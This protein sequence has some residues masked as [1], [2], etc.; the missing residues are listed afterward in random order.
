MADDEATP[1]APK[2]A[3]AGPTQSRSRAARKTTARKATAKSAQRPASASKPAR[4]TAVRKPTRKTSRKPAGKAQ[5]KSASR[6]PAAARPITKKIEVRSG[7]PTPKRPR[8][9]GELVWQ[10]AMAGA[11]A[12]AA[13]PN[14]AE[15]FVREM[16]KRGDLP[17]LEGDKIIKNI[18]KR[19]DHARDRVGKHAGRIDGLLDRQVEQILARLN[20]PTKSD[21]QNLNASI[22]NLTRKVETLSRRGESK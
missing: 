5:A 14:E 8:G 10:V 9:L 15:K 3:P 12:I 11:G 1:A 6:K 18:R 20:V 19:T 21:I 2:A 22:D 17:K 16:V 7:T 13:A 4:K